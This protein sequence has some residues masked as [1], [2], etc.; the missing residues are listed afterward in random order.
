MI[1]GTGTGMNPNMLRMA[2]QRLEMQEATQTAIQLT[3]AVGVQ[4]KDP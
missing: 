2:L 3:M 1:S 4:K